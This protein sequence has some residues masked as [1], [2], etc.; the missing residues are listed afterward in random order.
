MYILP[1]IGFIFLYTYFQHSITKKYDY[2]DFLSIRK[3]YDWSDF[4]SVRKEYDYSDFLSIRKEYDYSDFL[5][6][7]KE[8]DCWDDVLFKL[9][10]IQ[11]ILYHYYL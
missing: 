11:V 7:R 9:K 3:K 5:S 1:E 8:Y 10:T 2:S 4:L 6:I